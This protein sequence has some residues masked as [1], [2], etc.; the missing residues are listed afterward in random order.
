MGVFSFCDRYILILMVDLDSM[1]NFSLSFYWQLCILS[2]FSIQKV[3]RPN[4]L[5][6]FPKISYP[7]K[8]PLKK[9][10]NQKVIVSFKKFRIQKVPLYIFIELFIIR[11]LYSNYFLRKL[12]EQLFTNILSQIFCE[13]SRLRDFTQFNFSPDCTQKVRINSPDWIQIC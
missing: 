4:I 1:S 8:Y 13:H 11:T 2:Y 7:T 9:F 10:F 6:K 12:Y 5:W 3:L